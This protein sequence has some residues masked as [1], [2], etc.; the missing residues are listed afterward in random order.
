LDG[1]QPATIS[2]RLSSILQ[3]VP[4]GAFE[5]FLYRDN[6]SLAAFDIQTAETEAD[7]L[8]LELIA[9]RKDVEMLPPGL[10]RVSILH[11]GFGLPRWAAEKWDAYLTGSAPRVDPLISSIAKAI[12]K[13]S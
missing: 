5:D 12:K 4:L 3:Q 7:M 6:G 9:P 10:G 1:E 8:A 11:T 13:S 2:E